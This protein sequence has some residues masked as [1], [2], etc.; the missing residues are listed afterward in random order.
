M[1]SQNVFIPFDFEN[2]WIFCKIYHVHYN[3][4][5]KIVENIC[6][7]NVWTDRHHFLF[8]VSIFP[9]QFS[10]HITYL[11]NILWKLYGSLLEQDT[12]LGVYS[13]CQEQTWAYGVRNFWGGGHESAR[14][15]PPKAR[16]PLGGRRHALREILKNRVFLMP[17]PVFGVGFIFKY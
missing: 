10:L 8:I 6:T 15:A 11:S 5:L 2:T 16:E 1:T 9:Q 7:D 3:F 12:C 17:F 4:L 13:A 14:I